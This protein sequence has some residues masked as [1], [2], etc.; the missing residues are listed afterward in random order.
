MHY[1]DGSAP[2][3]L[4]G[5]GWAEDGGGTALRFHSPEVSRGAPMLNNDD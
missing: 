1:F 3:E 2:T 5:S 4:R